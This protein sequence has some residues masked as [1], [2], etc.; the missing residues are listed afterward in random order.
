[1]LDLDAKPWLFPRSGGAVRLTGGLV[2]TIYQSLLI[3]GLLLWKEPR[4]A[5]QLMSYYNK[6]HR[7][8]HRFFLP[9]GRPSK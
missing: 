7:S 8:R 1:M 2:D 4:A 6:S 9:G 3:I 5:N